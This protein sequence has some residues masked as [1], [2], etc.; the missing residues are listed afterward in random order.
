VNRVRLLAQ[1]LLLLAATV[2]PAWVY[3]DGLTWPTNQL[4][5]SFSTP[6]AVL[7][8]IDISSAS[9]AEQDL[10]ASLQGVVN[11]TQP[12]VACVSSV[13]GESKFTWLDLHNLPYTLV[14]GYSALLKYKTNFTGLVVT[15]PT[16]PDTLNLATTIAGVNNQ[17]ICDPSLLS[18]LTNSPYSFTLGTDLRGRF[19]DP[20]QVYRYL[21][22][23]YWPQCTHRMLSGLWTN[24]HGN[25]RDYLVAVKAATLWLDP[26]VATDKTIMGLFIADI[27]PLKGIYTGWWP[28]EANGLNW[29]SPYGIPVLASDYF[30]NGTVYGGL[31]HAINVP[32]IPPPPPLQN[33]VYVAFILSDGDNI[34]YM[35]HAMKIRWAD[36]ARGTIPIGWTA[37]PL[38]LDMDPML[39]NHYWSTATRN[40]CLVSGPSGAG[41]T[42]MQNWSSANLAAFTKATDPYLKRS[43]LRLIT[44]WDQVTTG[45]ARSFATNC[46]SLLGLTDQS[47]GNYTSVNLGLRTLG[48]T[49]SYSSDTNAILSGITNAAKNW[50]GNSPLFLAVQGNVW[51]I[52]PT[53]LRTVAS[54][55]DTNKYVLVRPDHLFLLY[56]AVYDYP[57]AATR[58]AAAITP[59]SA[60]LQGT[61]RPNAASAQAWMEWGTNDGYGTKTATLNVSG[62]S[63]VA[64][65]GLIS[66][67]ASRTVYHFRVA[68]S[69]TLGVVYGADKTFTVGH[70][71]KA[72]GDSSLG[73]T[74]LPPDLTNVVG[75]AGGVYHGLALKN[76]GSVVAWGDNALGQINVPTGLGNVVEVAAGQNH[77]LALKT[78]GTVVVWGDN[79]Q[80]QTNLPAGLSDVVAIAAG[81][82]H[83]LALKADGTVAAWGAS[84]SGQTNVPATLSNVVAIA[85]GS[86]HNL[87]LKL[88]G[89]VTAWGSNTAGQ[90]NVPTGL[91]NVVA[92][93]A[94][95]YHSLALKADGFATATLQPSAQWVADSLTGADGTA[96]GFWP[97]QT[98]GKSAAQSATANRPRLYSN[99]LNG[100]KVVRFASSSSQYLTVQTTNNPIAAAGSFTLIVVFKTSTAGSASTYFYFN[101]GLLGCEQPNI[102]ADWALCL[103]GSQLG[104]GLGGGATGCGADL[105]LYGGNVTD[106]LPHIAMYVRYGDTVSLYVDGVRVVTQSSL[107]TNARGNYNFQIGAMTTS[108]Y[109]FNGDIAEIQLFDRGLNDWEVM[110]ANE[111]L[112]ATYG[113][114]NVARTVVA[115]GSNGFG[116]TNGPASLTHL[117]AVAGGGLFNL[118]LREDGSVMAWGNNTQGQTNLPGGL[119]NVAAIAA[120]LG[121]GLALG[122]QPPLV[123]NLTCSGFA[124][125]D[126][127][128]P[129]TA[130][131]PDGQ[132]LTLRVAALPA[133][134]SLYQYANGARSTPVSTL[135]TPVS[136]PSG[137]LVFAPAPAQTGAPYTSFSF[138]AEDGFYRSG[139]AQVTVNIG[140]PDVPQ[141]AAP[142][143]S[144]ANPAGW[145]LRF[146]GSSNATYSVWASTNLFTWEK[147]GTADESS[148][149]Q[150]QFVDPAGTNNAQCF[151]RTTA[152]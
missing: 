30:R 55:L 63:P 106:G 81:A 78:D 1:R 151:Y 60:T 114:G 103:N 4:L 49:V 71:L 23:N 85:A 19:T 77:S 96:I 148:P 79:A 92:V 45:V 38:A 146:A 8:C 137:R 73:Q 134:G 88:D 128:L 66:G 24:L 82:Y 145:A 27:P 95:Q 119:T 87:A 35:Q 98:A 89:T 20:Y 80:G 136:D 65:K 26:G 62:S 46:P 5:P 67:L 43:G 31:P 130:T 13:D 117:A 68:V 12:R 59:S 110:S 22:T 56:N 33:K 102:V 53:H 64:V 10:F 90:T 54:A 120:G 122:N 104:A 29:I 34:Q 139:T 115:W 72:W 41:Y 144:P 123:N 58:A 18:T 40:D 83:S 99:A 36:A 84:T 17:L 150:Y 9:A 118:A 149:G 124:S 44:V 116:Q 152:P 37:S 28:S 127:I 121:F 108:S 42:H 109:F 25:L 15:D 21:Y 132:P 100:H 2:A 75:A 101:T 107:C 141:L 140:L 57:A 142:L 76:D 97:D 91:S 6:A 14:S 94:G 3:A 113:I 7:D 111:R 86:A 70:R 125:H 69:N 74:N 52:T 147:L 143:W 105:S 129:L 138:L 135:N 61:V 131:S 47:G 11:R 51:D 32:D 50:T 133:A 93:A 48:L 126:L 39:L 16:Q 112:A